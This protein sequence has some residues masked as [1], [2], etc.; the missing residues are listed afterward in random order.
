MVLVLAPFPLAAQDGAELEQQVAEIFERS[1]TQSGCHAGP[2]PQ[3]MMTLTSEGFFSSTVG[4]PSIEMPSLNRVQ[5]GDPEASYLVKKIR[6]DDDIIGLQMP[7]SGDKLNPEEVD[8]IIR[9]VSGLNDTDAERNDSTES[10]GTSYPFDGW[11]VVNL[12]TALTVNQGTW[13][14]LISHRFNPEIADGYDA[15][16]GL[17]GS[18]IIYLSMGYAV[19]D[20]LLL[21]LG[22]SNSA[23][24]VEL[25]GR[26]RV[27]D[28]RGTSPIGTATQIA[29]NW[30]SESPPGDESRLR[31][32][33]FKVS[34]QVAV[35]RQ[36]GR[37]GIAVVP[38]I[39]INPAEHVSG[40][41]PL[42]TIGLGG[43]WTLAQL[44]RT[45]LSLVG[46]WV[47]IV[48]GYTRTTTFGNDIRFDTGG[49][50]L[51]ISIGGHVFQIVVSNSVGLTSDQYLRGGDLDVADGE[52]RLG[53]NIFRTL[54]F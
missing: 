47:P 23:D 22:R 35:T 51:E 48:S 9:W 6:G 36:I 34:G 17:D 7:F 25:Q 52:M 14:F 2:N 46:E 49:G 16:Y 19:T 29:I 40:E 30:V 18:G 38:G 31:G 45:R 11:K 13:L 21:A 54:N 43:R 37:V 42:I 8:A 44:N 3:M 4:K 20:D 50:G 15:L 28:Q 5:P 26:Y 24:N 1:C 12:P 41:D 33:A 53:F 39:T 10:A 27:T 32:E